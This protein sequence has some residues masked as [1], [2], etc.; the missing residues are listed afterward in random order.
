MVLSR[1]VPNL[2]PGY[3]FE[4]WNRELVEGHRPLLVVRGAATRDSVRAGEVNG[5]G[6]VVGRLLRRAAVIRI[7][8]G[9]TAVAIVL[10]VFVRSPK[11][12]DVSV[13]ASIASAFVR[14]D[15]RGL[16]HL[17]QQRAL[18]REQS[19]DAAVHDALVRPKAVGIIPLNPPATRPRGPR[20]LGRFSWDR[21]YTVARETFMS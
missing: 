2:G 4:E 16:N 15:A 13:R 3:S 12:T 20:R 9:A 10:V 1:G 18:Q 21:N 6:I 8:V 7:R 5:I 19:Y 17:A 11:Q 14:V